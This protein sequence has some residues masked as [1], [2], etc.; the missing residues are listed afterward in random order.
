MR[1][2]SV[3]SSHVQLSGISIL[4]KEGVV[5]KVAEGGKV[6]IGD[7]AKIIDEGRENKIPGERSGTGENSRNNIE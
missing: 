4:F 5:Y 7:L 3:S 2:K 1:G 6:K